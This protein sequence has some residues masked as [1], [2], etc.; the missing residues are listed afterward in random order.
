MNIEI[1]VVGGGMNLRK[2]LTI[3]GLE[4]I[5]N[6]ASTLVIT[7]DFA[8]AYEVLTLQNVSHPIV[9]LMPLYEDGGLDNDNYRRILN[10]ILDEAYRVSSVTVI[11]NGD[12]LVGMSWWSR[13]KDNSRFQGTIKFVPG[14][15]SMVN[16]FYAIGRDPIEAGCIVVDVNRF[17]LFQY[18]TTPELDLLILDICSTGTRRTFLSNPSRDSQ[19]DSLCDILEAKYSFDHI[20]YLVFCEMHDMFGSVAKPTTIGKLR[21]E[22]KNVVFG[23]SLLIPACDPKSISQDFLQKLLL[24]S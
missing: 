4:A 22:L 8:T 5:K 6:S 17:L 20:A 13:L 18:E 1:C 24:S 2:H 11:V 12:P 23:S 15:S 16:T 10:A 19:W 9:D 7:G 21:E 14:I 3:E